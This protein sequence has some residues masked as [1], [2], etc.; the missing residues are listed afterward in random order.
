MKNKNGILLMMIIALS[1]MTSCKKFLTQL[2]QDSVA[3]QTFYNT[4]DQLNSALAA[5]YSELGN[6]DEATYSR[7]LSLEA[8]GSNDE[9]YLRSSSTVAASVYTASSSYANFGACW[10]D[11]YTGI[12]RANI[13]LEHLDGSAAPASIKNEIKGETLFLRAYYFFVLVSY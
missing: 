1:S 13:L 8:N 6:T 11:L 7:F 2:P 10:N 5:V 4:T 9:Y 12:E 3:P